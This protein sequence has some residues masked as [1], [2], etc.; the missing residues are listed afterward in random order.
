MS[1]EYLKKIR[2][3]PPHEYKKLTHGYWSKIT[4]NDID[5]SR[6][7]AYYLQR[8]LFQE[9]VDDIIKWKRLK[10]Q[11]YWRD[12]SKWYW[13][14]RLFQEVW[15]LMGCL[16]G[17]HKDRAEHELIQIASIAANFLEYIEEKE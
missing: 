2:E 14:W 1:E 13:L 9:P 3:T 6:R 5:K 12:K 11:Y 15:E 10:Y 7:E 17:Y 4:Q 8:K 16:I